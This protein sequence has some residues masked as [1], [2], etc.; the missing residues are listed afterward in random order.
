MKKYDLFDL[1]Q[2]S[3][4]GAMALHSF[5]IGY[6]GVSKNRELQQVFPRLNYF[7][8]VLPIVY[9]KR[10][11]EVVKGSNE[12]YTVLSKDS[13]II[14]ELQDR[15]NKM[16]AMTFSCLNMAFSKGLLTLNKDEG[17]I[18]LGSVSRGNKIPIPLDFDY[19]TN[20]VKKIQDCAQKLGAIF[21]KR[22]IK[23]IQFELNIKF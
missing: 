13:T 11:L 20:S 7:F 15:A 23:N 14:L 21:A 8:Y 19:E 6:H 17:T 2:N 12:L 22:D 9:N 1:L 5:T 10:A 18:E 3:V 4:L 16:S